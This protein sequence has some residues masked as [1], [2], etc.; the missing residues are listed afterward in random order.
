MLFNTP[1]SSSITLYPT[2]HIS[3]HHKI[4]YFHVLII[5]LY[6]KKEGL[7]HDC[8][9]DTISFNDPIF[10][11]LLDECVMYSKRNSRRPTNE[12]IP[13]NKY[14]SDYFACLF[15]RRGYVYIK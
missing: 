11:K 1:I 14:F 10:Y 9:I 8:T 6:Y 2:V 5:I 4:S 12:S 13:Y 3:N 7:K 15:L